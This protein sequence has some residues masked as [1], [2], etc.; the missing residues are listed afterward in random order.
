MNISTYESQIKALE[1]GGGG[2]EG[3]GGTTVTVH[4]TAIDNTKFSIP[5]ADMANLIDGSVDKVV[6]IHPYPDST[7]TA[8]EEILYFAG[9]DLYQNEYGYYFFGFCIQAASRIDH[10]IAGNINDVPMITNINL[11]GAN[12]QFE[13]LDSNRAIYKKMN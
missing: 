1:A 8:V 6:L 7:I 9:T 10:F 5:I 11:S 4:A 12:Y 2:G 13:S 3:G